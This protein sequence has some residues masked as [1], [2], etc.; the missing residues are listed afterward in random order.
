MFKGGQI[1]G[2]LD[3]VVT[4]LWLIQ[5]DGEQGSLAAPVCD[6]G[7]IEIDVPEAVEL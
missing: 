5:R 7:A 3:I 4:A 2:L 6:Q 1:V